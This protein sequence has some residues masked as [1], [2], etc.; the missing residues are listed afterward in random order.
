MSYAETEREQNRLKLMREI[1]H[2]LT[3]IA[4]DLDR[5]APYFEERIIGPAPLNQK[6]KE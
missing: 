6:E 2:T 5:I 4:E 3:K 1:L